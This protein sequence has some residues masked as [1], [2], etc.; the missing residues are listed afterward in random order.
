M[1]ITVTPYLSPLRDLK[2]LSCSADNGVGVP[3]EAVKLVNVHSKSPSHP[4]TV[5]LN[6]ISSSRSS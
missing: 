5:S 4:L 3:L 6:D 1:I 2:F